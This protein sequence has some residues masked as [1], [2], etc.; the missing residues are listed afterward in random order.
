MACSGIILA[1]GKSLRMGQDKGLAVLH[2]KPMITYAIAAL[3]PLV[4]D[5]FIIAHPAAYAHFGY[6]VYQDNFPDTGPLGGI[7]TGLQQSHSAYNLIMSCDTPFVSS[8]LL[9]HLLSQAQSHDAILPVHDGQVEPLTALYHQR[10][11]TTFEELIADKALK[12]LNAVKQVNSLKVPID[13]RFG[14]YHERLF[15]NLN[16]PQALA[17]AEEWFKGR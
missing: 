6:P 1:G 8:D 17:A 3:K 10:C 5:I 16:T 11:L 15:D 14:F 2:N 7:V 13:Q 12:L 9:K 4:S